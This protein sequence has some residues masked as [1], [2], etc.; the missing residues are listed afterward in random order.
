MM[1]KVGALFSRRRGRCQ[2]TRLSPIGRSRRWSVLRSPGRALLRSVDARTRRPE[3][4][5]WVGGEGRAGAP[6]LPFRNL[7]IPAIQ[8]AVLHASGRASSMYGGENRRRREAG[9]AW[10][11]VALQV[12]VNLRLTPVANEC[13]EST[14]MLL[15]MLLRRDNLSVCA[16]EVT[17][18][19]ITLPRGPLSC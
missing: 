16:A 10:N 9:R 15:L 19:P 17:Q 12:P 2:G 3:R 5:A 4:M 8:S 11:R 14:K 6:E 18:P 1:M 7:V 13:M